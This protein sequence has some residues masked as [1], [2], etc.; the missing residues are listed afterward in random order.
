MLYNDHIVG[1]GGAHGRYLNGFG[2]PAG[3][4]AAAGFRRK[5]GIMPLLPVLH[6]TAR[7]GART[8]RVTWR[9]LGLRVLSRLGLRVANLRAG[10][11]VLSRVPYDVQP[12][13]RDDA[14]LV[15]RKRMRPAR[16]LPLGRGVVLVAVGKEAGDVG[17]EKVDK[18]DW[19]VSANETGKPEI[20]PVTGRGWVAARPDP[21]PRA[22][23]LFENDTMQ[24]LGIRHVAWLLDRYRVDLVLDVGAN[25][26]QYAIKLR[27]NG[28]RGHI[29]SF[30]PVPAFASKLA[31]LAADDERWVVQQ[32]ALGSTDG[33]VPL[34]VQRTFSSMLAASEY[35]KQRFAPLRE[36]AVQE[37]IVEVPLRRLDALLDELLRGVGTDRGLAR[38]FLKMDT[39]GFD[40]EVFRGLGER[41]EQVV[42]LQSEMALLSIYEQMPRMPE[43]LAVYEAAGFEISGLYPVTS[44]PDGRVIE[45]DCVMVRASAYAS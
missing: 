39:Q 44:E 25:V 35:G 11:A 17:V 22:A 9:R 32:V 24:L 16:V 36:G 2:P 41:L 40:L 10:A 45:Y 4:V 20:M 13:V 43:A 38:V 28:F 1:A 14:Y 26:G 5:P 18:V 12:V 33:L 31:K 42:G 30:E 37:Q 34:R 29:V 19:W 21:S 27:R 7:S 23:A 3:S 8:S 15:S 6:R